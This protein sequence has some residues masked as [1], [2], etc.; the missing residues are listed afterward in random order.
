MPSVLPQ[1]MHSGD[2]M[3]HNELMVLLEDTE[4]V[5][6]AKQTGR[7]GAAL[8]SIQD[9]GPSGGVTYAPI[10]NFTGTAAELEEFRRQAELDRKTFASRV[11]G[12]VRDGT[13]RRVLK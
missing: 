4:N 1:K 2:G 12:A 9:A 3:K 7:I 13:K 10:N 8:G 5:I 11:I 6:T